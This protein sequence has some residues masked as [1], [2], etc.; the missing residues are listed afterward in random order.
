MAA[1]NEIMCSK[2]AALKELERFSASTDKTRE[3]KDKEQ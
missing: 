2:A 3:K 1:V